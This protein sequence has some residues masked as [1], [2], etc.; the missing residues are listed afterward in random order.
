MKASRND[1]TGRGRDETP[2][3]PFRTIGLVDHVAQQFAHH[4]LVA[5]EPGQA[6][7]AAHG[8]E[9]VADL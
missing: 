8:R 1:V 7:R 2:D 6:R 9:G 5:D 3:A 4:E